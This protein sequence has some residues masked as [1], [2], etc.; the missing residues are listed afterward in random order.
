MATLPAM[1]PCRTHRL[2][3]AALLLLAGLVATAP[4][5]RAADSYES[6]AQIIARWRE[7]VA[8]YRDVPREVRVKESKAF[9]ATIPWEN[10]EFLCRE[11]S[12]GVGPDSTEV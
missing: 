10:L 11:G 5:S 12:V 6:L 1:R 9:F 2:R 8:R 3:A 4:A 7:Y